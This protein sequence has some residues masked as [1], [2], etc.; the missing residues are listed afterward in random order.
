VR[1]ILSRKGF[2]SSW[3][4][5]AC[6]ILSGQLLLPLPIPLDPAGEFAGGDALRYCDLRVR[7][8]TTSYE[9]LMLA[10]GMNTLTIGGV[11]QTLTSAIH[12]HLDPDLTYEITDRRDG[13]KG[14]FGQ[15]D[16]AEGHLRN[17]GIAVGDLFLFFGLFR[18]SDGARF[19][20]REQR[21]VLFGYLQIGEIHRT[22]DT[23]YPGAQW[24]HP[25][26]HRAYTHRKERARKNAVYVASEELSLGDRRL[27]VPGHGTF[28]YAEALVLTRAQASSHTEWA[29]PPFFDVCRCHITPRVG[30]TVGVGTWHFFGR[31]IAVKSS[32]SL[33]T[34]IR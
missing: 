14:A 2:D 6:P 20:E 26:F 25:H 12:C 7:G 8:T 28:R 32:S 31:R 11:R 21:H 19:V 33:R 29:L 15:C 10:H 4:G 3:G 27:G 5:H 13:W 9:D 34:R 16:A 17:Q 18:H 22:D 24:A 23:D 1:F 30:R